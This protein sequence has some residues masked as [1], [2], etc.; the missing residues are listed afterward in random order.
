MEYR[1]KILHYMERQTQ[2]LEQLVILNTKGKRA[3]KRAEPF[4]PPTASE[5]EAYAESKG[6]T[7]DGEAVVFFYASKNWM[8][9]KNKMKCWKSAVDGW[10]K[11]DEP[12]SKQ[13]QDKPQCVFCKI[14]QDSMSHRDGLGYVCSSP[15][16]KQKSYEGA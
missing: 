1:D 8:V 7:V 10:I 12:V 6:K 11:R 2:A 13:V 16:C 14:E 9:G 5:I 4:K 15:E 3:T